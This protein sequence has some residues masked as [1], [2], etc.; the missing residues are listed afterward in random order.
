M[1]NEILFF[2]SVIC[3]FLFS[4]IA[5]KLG[6]AYLTAMVIAQ[7]LIANIFL[8]KEISL[9]GL[10]VSAADIFIIGIILGI[11]LLE[12]FFDQNSASD[13]INGYLF[14]LA[15]FFVFSI[16]H[17]T[18]V[19]TMYDTTH[20]SFIQIFQFSTRIIFATFFVSFCSLH[21]DRFLYRFLSVFLGSSYLPLKNFLTGAISQFFDT[22]AFSYIAVYGLFSNIYNIIFFSYLIKIITLLLITPFLIIAKQLFNKTCPTTLDE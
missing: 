3:V 8:V 22:V 17:K 13:A 7:G 19:P 14:S 6:K 15:L 20:E 12:E 1:L 2:I 9:F 4:L 11:N 18:Y 10:A 21:L 5:L 16:I